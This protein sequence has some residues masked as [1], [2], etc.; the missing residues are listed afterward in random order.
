M[1]DIQTIDTYKPYCN[2][3]IIFVQMSAFLASSTGFSF[4]LVCLLMDFLTDP[5]VDFS[6]SVNV[7]AA[8]WFDFNSKR[9]RFK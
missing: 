4:L 1:N 9:F 6:W 3:K 2:A 7:V 8:M 5:L